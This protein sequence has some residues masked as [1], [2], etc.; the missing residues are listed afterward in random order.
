L[1]LP[2]GL[3]INSIEIFLLIFVRMT[4]LFLVSPIFGRRNIPSIFKVGFSFML[5]LILSN[6]I[7]PQTIAIGPG[8][9]DYV[10]LVGKEF[11]VGISIGY[12]SYLVFTA[13]YFA[14]QLIDI[15]IGFGMVNVLDPMSN[16]Q[17]PVTANFYFI[18]SMFIF[19]AINGHHTLIRA[20]FDSFKIIPLG[21]AVFPDALM[22]DVLRVFGSIFTFGF[23]IA[24]P[25]TAAILITDVTLGIMSRT[26]PQLNVFVVGMPLKILL[27]IIVIMITMPMFIMLL[28]KIFEMMNSEMLRF[29]K[30]MVP[31]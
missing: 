30:D 2:F 21:S 25:L 4:G 3:M 8:I 14:G 19:L 29:L 22:V 23:K 24:A 9:L 11:L 5:T 26:V 17:I 13:I 10:V 27:G 16:I 6:T 20:L 7:K 15:Q 28:Q 31:I 1:Q 12:V 18:L